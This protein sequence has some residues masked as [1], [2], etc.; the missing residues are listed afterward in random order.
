M[1]D[2][3]TM[4]LVIIFVAITLIPLL[5]RKVRMPVII[6][7]IIFGIIIGRSLF[8]IVPTDSLIDFFSSFGLVYLLF[9]AGLDINFTRLRR[10]FS[11]TVSIALFSVLVPFLIGVVISPSTGV[12]PLL[13]GTIF[14][15]TS[16]G[17]VLPLTRDLRSRRGFVPLLLA[18][19]VLVDMISMFLLAFSLALVQGSMGVS[20][21]YSL[22]AVIL[23]F[24]IPWV[25]NLGGA[26]KRIERWM[27]ER[28]HFEMEVRLSF[29]V[30]LIFGAVSEILGFHAII[31]AFIAGLLMSELTSKASLLE[32]K[33]EGFG[34]GFFIPLFFIITGSKVDLNLV[35]LNVG[36]INLLFLV[37]FLGISSKLGSVWVVAWVK[38]LSPRECASLGFFHAA[39]LS[40]IIAVADIGIRL[41]FIDIGMFSIIILFVLVSSIVCPW[42]GKYSLEI[43]R[44]TRR[45]RREVSSG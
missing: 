17:L 37:I 13:M 40:L 10:Y 38:G 30:I 23:L 5:A 34:Y 26:Q 20:F 16:V 42:A 33:L 12:H 11:R 7:E 25:I 3:L 29:A 44:R 22:I 19:V 35:F 15:T 39:R 14:S 8:D 6:A 1:L 9:L 4:S 24:I 21:L 18:S 36:N 45:K 27:M 43:G 41:G 32:K 31:G 28:S 2:P